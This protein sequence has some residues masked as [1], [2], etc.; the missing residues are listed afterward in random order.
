MS[1]QPRYLGNL[2]RNESSEE[3]CRPKARAYSL[4]SLRLYTLQD[5][6]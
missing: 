6:P 1:R 2:L 4:F 5:G 3:A